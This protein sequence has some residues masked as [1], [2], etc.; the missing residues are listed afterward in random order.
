MRILVPT[1]KPELPRPTGKINIVR[2]L[3]VLGWVGYVLLFSMIFSEG[4]VRFPHLQRTV[5]L[6]A[7][8]FAGFLLTWWVQRLGGLVL[9]LSMIVAIVFNPTQLKEWRPWFF[10]LEGYMALTGVLFIIAPRRIESKEV[11]SIDEPSANR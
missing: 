10:A 6:V 1:D 8:S 2:T 5:E 11:T 9:A 3:A 7:I 4:M